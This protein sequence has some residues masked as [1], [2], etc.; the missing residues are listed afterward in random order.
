[1]RLT[2]KFSR[3]DTKATSHAPRKEGLFEGLLDIVREKLGQKTT[4]GQKDIKGIA[5]MMK[6][7]PETLLKIVNFHPDFKEPP[8][9]KNHLEVCA[10][11]GCAL[12]DAHET[13]EFIRKRVKIQ[14]EGV[15]EDQ[16]F[17]LRLV[18]CFGECGSGPNIKLNGDQIYKEMSVEKAADLLR[19]LE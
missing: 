15:S 13:I 11:V 8:R 19:G 1:M 17:S 16:R 2:G 4:N 9:G 3:D 18:D 6:I 5:K 7:T 14:G 12:K 10:N